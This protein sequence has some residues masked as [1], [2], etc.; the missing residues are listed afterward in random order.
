MQEIELKSKSSAFSDSITARLN[1]I[2]PSKIPN[3]DY[4]SYMQVP[5]SLKDEMQHV[6]AYLSDYKPSQIV[7]PF[8]GT[9]LL[10][11]K[12]KS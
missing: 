10:M 4:L 6:T 11:S 7:T 12:D 5:R 1:R 2:T 9:S 8:K 3:I